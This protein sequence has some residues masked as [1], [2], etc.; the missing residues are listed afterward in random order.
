MN[1]LASKIE[2]PAD[3]LKKKISFWL[4][5]GIIKETERN[6]FKLVENPLDS[7]EQGFYR[8]SIY[9][10]TEDLQL[11]EAEESISASQAQKEE[12]MKV[13]EN[14]CFGMLKTFGSLT[15]DRIQSSL[16]AL[17]DTYSW[18]TQELADFLNQL[19]KDHKLDCLGGTYAL[20]KK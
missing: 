10:T 9:L 14:F 6:I 11:E 2:V 7:L 5:N 15:L 1:E 20:H 19:V 12:T 3:V 17:V 4:N 18:N 16:S 8:I 13:V